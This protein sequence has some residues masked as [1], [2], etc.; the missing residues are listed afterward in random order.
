LPKLIARI[1]ADKRGATAIEYGLIVS[2]IFLVVIGGI[3]T[4]GQNMT[5]MFNYISTSVTTSLK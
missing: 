3:G 1:L 4:F 5:T 2:L